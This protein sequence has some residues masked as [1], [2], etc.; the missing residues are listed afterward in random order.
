MLIL[1][2]SVIFSN[3]LV[4]LS[5]K[6]KLRINMNDSIN[7]LLRRQAA[8]QRAILKLQQSLFEVQSQLN[9]SFIKSLKRQKKKE[10]KSKDIMTSSEVCD[11]LKISQSTL[12][13]MELYKGFPYTRIPGQKKLIFSRMDIMAYLRTH[14]ENN[15]G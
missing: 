5:E 1:L 7:K 2:V 14:K 10:V 4:L 8:L 3:H 6:N 12:R 11:M 9:D 15:Y 13:R